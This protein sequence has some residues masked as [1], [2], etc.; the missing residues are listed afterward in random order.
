MERL[1]LK[2]GFSSSSTVKITYSKGKKVSQLDH[3]LEKQHG[4][5]KMD[6]KVPAKWTAISDHRVDKEIDRLE[7]AGIIE[8][9]EYSP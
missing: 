3:V 1:Y 9:V 8:R 7:G 2:N 4:R 5:I 6:G